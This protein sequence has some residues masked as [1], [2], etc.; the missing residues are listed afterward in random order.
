MA[1]LATPNLMGRTGSMGDRR[2]RR[3]SG[4]SRVSCGSIMLGILLASFVMVPYILVGPYVV[5]SVSLDTGVLGCN[6]HTRISQGGIVCVMCTARENSSSVPD[7]KS[8]VCCGRSRGRRVCEQ[9]H[10]VV[11]HIIYMFYSSTCNACCSH[12]ARYR[13]TYVASIPHRRHLL[14]YLSMLQ[15]AQTKVV[16]APS[17]FVGLSWYVRGEHGYGL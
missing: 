15:G 2:L 13:P 4:V 7:K 1:V 3:H 10:A 6:L 14:H 11:R 5:F 12:H 16:V 8:G 9:R 17:L